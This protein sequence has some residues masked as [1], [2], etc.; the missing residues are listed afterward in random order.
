MK[1]SEFRLPCRA[2]LNAPDTQREAVL[3]WSTVAFGRGPL[4]FNTYE[5]G[6]VHSSVWRFRIILCKIAEVRSSP[7]QREQS[8]VFIPGLCTNVRTLLS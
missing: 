6:M 3:Q 1:G 5:V 8:W 7:R 4:N 2:W